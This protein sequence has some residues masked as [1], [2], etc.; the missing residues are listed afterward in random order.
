MWSASEVFEHWAMPTSKVA[1][2]APVFVSVPNVDSDSRESS[3]GF[4]RPK[5]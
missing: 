1:F 3:F 2:P 5:E 4:L